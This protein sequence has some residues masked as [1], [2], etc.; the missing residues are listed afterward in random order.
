MAK[1]VPG[2][3]KQR[4]RQHVIADISVHYVEGFILEEGH[5]AQRLSSDYS[6]DL[7]LRTFDEEGYAE[8]GL[9]LIQLKAAESLQMAGSDYVFDVDVRDYQLW[10]I[11]EMP[12]LLI[13]F[14]ASRRKAYWLAVQRYFQ[15]DT[16]RQPRIG[17][18]TVRVHIPKRQAVNRRAIRKIHVL[19]W[20]MQKP[21]LGVQS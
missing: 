5:T 4:T 6:Y 7:L 10:I 12:V 13:L 9:V 19:K 8:A 20:E 16:A 15:E 1:Q 21:K 18:K 17:A 2:P 11:E 3:R 14:D